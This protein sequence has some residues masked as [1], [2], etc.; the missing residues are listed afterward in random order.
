MNHIKP[1]LLAMLLAVAI[2][3]SGGYTQT[4]D[5]LDEMLFNP[6][7]TIGGYGEMHYNQVKQENGTSTGTLDF[8]RFVLFYS[9]A[10]TEQWSLKS[11]IELEHN[12]V[13]GGQGE[14]ELEQAFVDYHHSTAFGFQAG[15]IL[16]SV[17]LINEYHEPPLFF[18][19][20]RPYYA[21]YIVPTT[22]FGNGAAVYG[23]LLGVDYR[24]V[25]MEGL[26]GSKFSASS[27]LRSGR[28]KGY[29]AEA[30]HPLIN[31]KLESRAITGLIFGG[32][33]SHMK[34]PDTLNSMSKVNPTTLAEV[35]L[36]LN[37]GGLIVKG[38]FG[39]INYGKPELVSGVK[40]ARGYYLDLGYDI[41]SPLNLKGELIPWFRYS[42]INTAAVSEG[43]DVSIEADHHDS[44]WMVG[45]QLKP[46]PQV[47]YKLDYGK[48]TP[49]NGTVSTLFNLGVGYMF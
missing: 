18:G 32:S 12:F 26:D 38:E 1:L 40:S 22:W 35:H 19:V 4:F 23:N 48:L 49:E 17:G 30:T 20:E 28:Q 33:F 34:A 13:K 43:V 10:W 24:F 5:G 46:I 27:G 29:K 44:Q 8:H 36:D 3:Y 14:L 42:D 45:V 9:H 41:A 16:P 47:V 7:T 39:Q 6:K 21:K 25:L 15:V 2:P 37:R 31:L 11:E